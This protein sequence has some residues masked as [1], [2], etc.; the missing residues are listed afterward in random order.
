MFEGTLYQCQCFKDWTILFFICITIFYAI[1]IIL[2]K[3]FK[4]DGDKEHHKESIY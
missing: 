4:V 1:I 2:K 3:I